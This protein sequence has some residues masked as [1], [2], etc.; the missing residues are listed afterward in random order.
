MEVGRFTV[1]TAAGAG[2]RM[3]KK[4]LEAEPVLSHH[5]V[6][7]LDLS[8]LLYP[9]TCTVSGAFAV[10]AYNDA[11]VKTKVNNICNQACMVNVSLKNL[12]IMSIH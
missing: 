8:P 1:P 12:H 3:G 6:A 5:G 9:G 7:Y 4:N 10:Y 11:D 2:S